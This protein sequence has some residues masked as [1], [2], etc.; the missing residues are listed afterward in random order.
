MPR[1]RNATSM[2][3][4]NQHPSKWYSRLNMA[5]FYGYY[6]MESVPD[7][8][9]DRHLVW[10]FHILF[11][12]MLLKGLFTIVQKS[13]KE[14]YEIYPNTTSL[15]DE[16]LVKHFMD[17]DSIILS[18]V[19][20]KCNK[21]KLIFFVRLL[22]LVSILDKNT[23]WAENTLVLHWDMTGMTITICMDQ[24]FLYPL[25]YS[26]MSVFIQY[27]LNNQISTLQERM[28]GILKSKVAMILSDIW[29]H[30]IQPRSLADAAIEV[31]S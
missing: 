21:K 19:R 14:I 9:T 6:G 4:P 13:Q 11:I 22:A 5:F 28:R 27:R 23:F 2:S 8:D 17:F 25:M 24:K 15:C 7:S 1:L 10:W 20:R 12:S 29:W 31:V 26:E 16:D 30:Q 18:P 3:A